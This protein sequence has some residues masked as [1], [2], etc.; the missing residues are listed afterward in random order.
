M[1]MLSFKKAKKCAL[2]I[3]CTVVLI[4]S[5]LIFCLH[6]ETSYLSTSNVPRDAKRKLTIFAPVPNMMNDIVL[7]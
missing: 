6:L 5:L 3:V 4:R 1:I 2:V 7:E